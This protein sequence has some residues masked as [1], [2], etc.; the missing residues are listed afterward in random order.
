V[1]LAPPCLDA[2]TRKLAIPKYLAWTRPTAKRALG[3]AVVIGLLFDQVVHTHLVGLAGSIMCATVA[4]ALWACTHS[5]ATPPAVGEQRRW[6]MGRAGWLV[7]CLALTPWLTLRTSP[8]LIGPT[9]IAMVVLLI[10]AAVPQAQG[11]LT[12]PAIGARAID[13][14]SASF[15]APMELVRAAGA[16]APGGSVQQIRRS[17]FGLAL[18][19]GVAVFL[20]ILLSSGDA[21][22]A[23]ILGSSSVGARLVDI[24]LIAGA[25][26]VWFCLVLPSRWSVQGRVKR[27]SMFGIATPSGAPPSNAVFVTPRIGE[28]EVT[29]VLGSVVVVLSGY[30]AS[31]IAGALGGASYIERRTGLTYAEYARSGFFQLVAVVALV[32]SLLVSCRGIIRS[33]RSRR[34]LLGLAVI[35]ASCTL[36]MVAVSIARLQTYRSVFGL[37]ML[38]FSTTVFAGWLAVVMLL[39]VIALVR[40]AVEHLLVTAVIL[41]AFGTLMVTNVA[42]PEAIVARE[43]LERVDWTNTDV[44]FGTY[45]SEASFDGD[46]LADQLSDDAVPTMIAHLDR[47][48]VAQ[49]AAL[50]T[51][52]C[53]RDRVGDGWSWNRSRSRAASALD[54]VCDR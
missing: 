25:G 10:L 6:Q 15:D 46:Y 26:A 49:R 47:L 13:A 39:I 18:G 40:P 29:L 11:L 28:R 30:V 35:N 44:D 19:G 52:L 33:A 51:R 50:V 24:V 17:M 38:R 8:W 16:M 4:A 48:D 32:G 27:P 31:L 43:N 41:S 21:F 54:T 14:A 5:A 37:T 22:F 7:L 36:V 53:E 20:L 3:L 9:M 34:R 45:G 23:S 12:F 1:E 42:N 2:P